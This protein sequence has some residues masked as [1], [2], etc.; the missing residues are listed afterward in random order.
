[1]KLAWP[2]DPRLREL[3]TL[4]LRTAKKVRKPY[5]IG[6]AIAM[7]VHGYERHTND[8]DAFLLDDDREA[9]LHALQKEGLSLKTLYD[10]FHFVAWLPKHRDENVHIDLLFPA[11]PID[12]GAID[13]RVRR[14]F[15]GKTL[16]VV[17]TEMLALMKWSSERSEDQHDFVS[18]LKRD[19][20]EPKTAEIMLQYVD[21]RAAVLFRKDV[22]RYTSEMSPRGSR[23]L[24]IWERVR[25]RIR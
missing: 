19:L 12:V 20:F 13:G 17:P 8:L 9:W 1:V 10:P 21:P 25:Q 14:T 5:A 23:G 22:T 11:D 24:S 4:F 18:F 16:Q 7:A 15:R 6:G 3:L 2:A